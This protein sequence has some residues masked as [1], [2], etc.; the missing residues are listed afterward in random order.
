ME[1]LASVSGPGVRR[2]AARAAGDT[3]PVG[4][5]SRAVGERRRSGS[6]PAPCLRMWSDHEVRHPSAG[7]DQRGVH[8]VEALAMADTERRVRSPTRARDHHFGEG[9]A[10]RPIDCNVDW[11]W[12]ARGIVRERTIVGASAARLRVEESFRGCPGTTVSR[13]L[14][15]AASAVCEQ[16]HG[17]PQPRNRA[18]PVRTAVLRH[19]RRSVPREGV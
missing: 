13:M 16:D 12:R 8:G 4:E 10:Y 3:H 17:D 9:G 19:G 6:R 18:A 1:V 14:Q 11:R 2:L 5:R 15:P 7:C